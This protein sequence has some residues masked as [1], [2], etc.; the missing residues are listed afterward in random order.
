M[1]TKPYNK[2]ENFNLTVD[3]NNIVVEIG[4]ERGEGSSVWLYN[5]AKHLRLYNTLDCTIFCLN[6]VLF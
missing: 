5:W 2:L 1:G 3:Q 6:G 4:S